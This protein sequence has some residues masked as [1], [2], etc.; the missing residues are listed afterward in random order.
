MILQENL[1]PKKW[2]D[3]K[4]LNRKRTGGMTDKEVLRNLF[5]TDRVGTLLLFG[6]SGTGKTSAALLASHEYLGDEFAALY[7][8]MN[9]S[10]ERKL[11]DI[12]EKVKFFASLESGS[13]KRRIVH[14]D[15]AD[16]LRYDAQDALRAIV[17]E[18]SQNCIFIFTL[19]N[20]N[21]ISDAIKSRS[22][23][24]R[25]DPLPYDDVIDWFNKTAQFCDMN[26]ST[27][28]P[29][30]VL[31]YYKGDLRAVVSDFFTVYY[32]TEVRDFKRDDSYAEIVFKAEDPF[33]KY[34]EIASKE[35]INPHALL[36]DLFELNKYKSPDKFAIADNNIRNG[37]DIL[38]NMAYAI[39]HGVKK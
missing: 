31:S 11:T 29:R 22:A 24:F 21:K 9:A 20:I 5:A 38:I 34:L 2:E 39:Q 35:Y 25:F 15:E 3:L 28:L 32:G 8:K 36:H 23:I 12:R 13:D 26:I 30:E 6:P 4:G 16:G 14:L 17:E 27:N 10:D 33:L 7:L 37:G 1:R 18:Y 19:N